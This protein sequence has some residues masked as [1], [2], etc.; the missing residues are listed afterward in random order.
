MKRDSLDIFQD[1]WELEEEE[2][3]SIENKFLIFC[4]EDRD[5]GIPIHYVTE[6]I[7]VQEI[8]EVPEVP[9]FIIGVTSLRNKVVP[10]M[11]V[12]KRFGL[13]AHIFGDRDCLIILQLE[14]LPL[15]MLVESVKEVITVDPASLEPAPHFGNAPENRF[16]ANLANVGDKVKLLLDIP[17][18][19]RENDIA[20]VQK[21]LKS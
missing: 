3:D 2:E 13:D 17:K 1:E 9:S 15:A 8:S 11:D 18:L 20:S 5:Y 19:L 7:G 16:V 14:N 10:I 6:I 21:I 12:K 4:L